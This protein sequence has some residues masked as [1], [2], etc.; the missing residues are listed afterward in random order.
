M[1]TDSYTKM[2]EDGR[3]ILSVLKSA[4]EDKQVLVM[5]IARAYADG[6]MAG[7][8]LALSTARDSA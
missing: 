6:A 8:Q 5:A 1:D 2:V 7:E 3:D 4:R